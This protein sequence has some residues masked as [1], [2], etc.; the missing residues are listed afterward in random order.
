[1]MKV[2]E[3]LEDSNLI[4]KKDLL[5]KTDISYGQL[6][7]WKRKDLIPEQWFIKKSTYTGQGTFFPKEKILNRIS[8]IKELK[9][10][11]SLKEIAAIVSPKPADIKLTG[12][13]LVEEEI[14]TEE[15]INFFIEQIKRREVYNFNQITYMFVLDQ[16]ITAG[17]VDLEQRAILLNTM[18]EHYPKF[19]S[20]NCKLIFIRKRKVMNCLLIAD[21]KHIYFDKETEVVF[22][23][24]LSTQIEKLE[25]KLS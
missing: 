8:W 6:Y 21:T 2:G 20:E 12:S 13:E 23:M 1:M 24:D 9:Q 11:H 3:K 7:R 5:K 19:E 10:E 4:S 25:K 18:V 22:S 15:T 14:I 16:L 17:D